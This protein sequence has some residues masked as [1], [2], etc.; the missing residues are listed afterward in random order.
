MLATIAYA[1]PPKPMQLQLLKQGDWWGIISMAIGLASLEVVLEE[2]NRKDWFASEEI[3]QLA[4]V[5]VVFLS[6]F[7]FSPCH[8]QL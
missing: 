6:A 8:L 2:G 7:F 4:V 3:S 1:I 5:A